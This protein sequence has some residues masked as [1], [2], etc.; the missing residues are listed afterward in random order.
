MNQTTRRKFI[1]WMVSTPLFTSV[2][3]KLTHAN[4]FKFQRFFLNKFTVAGFQYYH[5]KNIIHQ[6]KDGDC[7]LLQAEPQNVYDEFAVGIFYEGHKLGYVP[8]SDNKHISRLLQQGAKLYCEVFEVS[9]ESEPWRMLKVQV[10][11]NV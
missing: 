10:F 9:P 2:L 8:K 6:L 1:L 11:L 5:G 3:N 4:L 7:L